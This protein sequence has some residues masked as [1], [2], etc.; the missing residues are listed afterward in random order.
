MTTDSIFYGS[1]LIA[2]EIE[3]AQR[4]T[5]GITVHPDGSVTLKAPIGAKLEEIQKKIRLEDQENQ[6]CGGC[7]V[8]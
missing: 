2:Y 7:G 4:K 6:I 3:Y 5:L 8:G 1:S